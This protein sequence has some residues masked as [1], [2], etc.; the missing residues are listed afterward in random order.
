MA[1]MD[2]KT[3]KASPLNSRWCVAPTDEGRVGYIDSE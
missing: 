3:L 1:Q 2:I